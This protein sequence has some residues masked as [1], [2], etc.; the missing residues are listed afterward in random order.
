M[1]G[2][3]LISMAKQ[4][5]SGLLKS[6]FAYSR[7]LVASAPNLNSLM[8][9][10]IIS[11]VFC[12]LAVASCVRSAPAAA[13]STDRVLLSGI[14]SRGFDFGATIGG[15]P[16]PSIDA[17]TPTPLGIDIAELGMDKIGSGGTTP[18]NGDTLSGSKLS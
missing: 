14:S 7:I 1:A 5:L 3:A 4:C 16:F 18:L 8:R 15:N 11:I 6:Q 2:Q 9:T 10:I 12:A 17:E 13:T